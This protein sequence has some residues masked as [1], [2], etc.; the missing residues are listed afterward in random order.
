LEKLIDTPFHTS[1]FFDR[2]LTVTGVGDVLLSLYSRP[3]SD[4]TQFQVKLKAA[5][6]L[7]KL[8]SAIERLDATDQFLKAIGVD[9][10]WQDLPRLFMD[11]LLP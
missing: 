10:F 3:T 4:E 9:K 2:Y 6:A 1:V 11:D 5:S 8:S 7:A